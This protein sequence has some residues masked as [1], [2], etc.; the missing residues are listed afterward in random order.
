M[1][2]R[3]DPGSDP[4]WGG[5]QLSSSRYRGISSRLKKGEEGYSFHR[6]FLKVVVTYALRA[7]RLALTLFGGKTSR[8]I[9]CRK[10][11]SVGRKSRNLV[12]YLSYDLGRIGA[13]YNVSMK[14]STGT[15]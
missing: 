4:G 2:G 1:S 6:P 13:R 11:N 7:Y 15:L 10:R 12:C 5:K 9:F 3:S 8:E 14:S